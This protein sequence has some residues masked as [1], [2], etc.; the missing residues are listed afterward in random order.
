M[1]LLFRAI[2]TLK[3]DTVARIQGGLRRMPADLSRRHAQ[4]PVAAAAVGGAAEVVHISNGHA[5]PLRNGS[6]RPAR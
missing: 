6:A 4:L 1:K 5:D 2:K 3:P